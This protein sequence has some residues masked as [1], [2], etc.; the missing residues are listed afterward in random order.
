MNGPSDDLSRHR[1]IGTRKK[2]RTRFLGIKSSQSTTEGMRLN[3]TIAQSREKKNGPV[4]VRENAEGNVGLGSSSTRLVRSSLELKCGCN[5]AYVWAGAENSSYTHSHRDC[6]AYLC[7][8]LFWRAQRVL[9]RTL[10]PLQT[11]LG[12][13]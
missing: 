8:L 13:Y 4:T 2:I 12:R 10:H 1:E 11:L 6:T 9:T 7:A 5:D 3:C